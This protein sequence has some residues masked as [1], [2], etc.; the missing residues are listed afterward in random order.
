[1][2]PLS[3]RSRSV[4]IVEESATPP[5]AQPGPAAVRGGAAAGGGAVGLRGHA[6]LEPL[7]HGDRRQRNGLRGPAGKQLNLGLLKDFGITE[8]VKLQFRAEVFNVTNTPQLTPPNTDLNNTSTT[9]GF[10]IINSTY[11]FTNR[12]I[13]FGARLQF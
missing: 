5:D 8:R 11:A 10:G 9:N 6:V 13:Q 4:V 2:R 3:S 1:M 7:E 12:Q